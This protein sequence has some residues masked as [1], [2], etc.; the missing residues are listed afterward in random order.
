MKLIN[1]MNI[2]KLKNAA[3]NFGTPLYVYDLSIIDRQIQKLK[4][5]FKKLNN[6]KIYFAAK[7]LSNISILKYINSLNLGIDAAS[8]EEVK[9]GIKCGFKTNMILFT[10]NGIDFSEVKEAMSLGVKINLDSLESLIDFSN[11]YPNQPVSIRINPDVLAGANENVSVGHLNSKF[12]IPEEQIQDII[13]ME[14]EKKIKVTA[15]HIHTGSDITDEN[16]FE[17]G[18]RKIFSHAYNFKNIDTIDLGG[19]IKIP[20]FNGD[21]ETNL[22]KY[23]DIINKEVQKFKLKKGKDLK[24]IFEPGKFL[25]SDSGYFITKVNYIKKT[26]QN[27]FVQVNSGFNHLIRPTLYRSHHEII[28]LSNPDFKEFKYSVVGYI[29]EKDT[30]ANK[31]MISKVSKGD[32]LC[33]KNSGAYGFSMTSNYNS[34]LKPAEVCI[35][36]DEIKKIREGEKF[37][38][39]FYG[40][41]DI[42]KD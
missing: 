38:D 25:V 16:H 15:L 40:Q 5:A 21:T 8:I 36:K 22:N 12:G 17:L 41:I 2:E 13:K 19:G 14:E 27:T 9:T 37:D 42:F 1:I 39:L 31:R 30:F 26:R 29:C 6:Y 10:P 32:L 35:Y 11:Y 24:L 23:A 18:I 20:Y 7:A 33:F 4:K 3:E 34:R 28:N